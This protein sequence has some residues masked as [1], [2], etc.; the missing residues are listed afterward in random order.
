MKSICLLSVLIF[1]SCQQP[2]DNKSDSSIVGNW[3]NSQME[4]C[5]KSV[6]SMANDPGLTIMLKDY[7]KS[8]KQFCEC[9]CE[10]IEKTYKSFD[11]ALEKMTNEQEHSKTNKYC[12]TG[13]DNFKK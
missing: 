4:K 10:E 7:N 3:E 1:L 13:T 6:K 2:L 5:K 9:Y 8:V 11:E 12:I